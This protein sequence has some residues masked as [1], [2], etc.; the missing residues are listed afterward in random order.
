MASQKFKNSHEIFFFFLLIMTKHSYDHRV[1]TGV[2]INTED[3]EKSSEG[4]ESS[5]QKTKE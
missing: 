5:S 1:Q 2:D 4:H 3:R